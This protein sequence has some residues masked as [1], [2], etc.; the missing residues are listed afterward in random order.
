[1]F[2][3]ADNDPELAN[4]STFRT[5]FYVTKVEPADVKE[6]VKLYDP[7]TKK[8]TS[9]K[10][11][12]KTAGLIYQVQFL[13]KDVSTQFNN[14]TYRILLYTHEGLGKDFF[15]VPADNLHKNEKARK[16]L[17]EYEALLTKF[18]SYVDCVVERKNGF[19]FIKDTTLLFWKS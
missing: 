2:H 9:A 7:K 16:Q 15:G 11:A 19:Y 8:V 14:N 12:A 17:E 4:K 10:G 5:S 3:Y 18:N 6:W 1:M 13:V